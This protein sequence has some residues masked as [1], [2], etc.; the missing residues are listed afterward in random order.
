[1]KK[2]K[3]FF[4]PEQYHGWGETRRYFEGWY[5]K[6]VDHSEKKAFAF[7]PGIAMDETGNRQA[8]I[9]V[10]DGKKNTAIY[11]KFDPSDFIP[12]PGKFEIRI[13][14]NFFSERKIRLNLPEVSGELYFSDN[15][16]WPKHWYSP[17]V[18]GPYSFAPFMECYHGLVSMDHSIK[19]QLEIEGRIINFDNGR[20]YIEKD[21]GRSFP[22][23]YIWMQT[24]HFSDPEI[25]LFASAAK[26]PWRRGS[27][28]GFISGIWIYDRLIQFTT[29][30]K[31]ILR[32]CYVDAGKVEMVME[33]KMHR[34]ELEVKRN[35]STALASPIQGFMA[36]RIE[37]SMTSEVKV[38]LTDVKSGNV[39]FQDKGRNAG[40]DVAGKVEELIV[41]PLE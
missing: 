20:G 36:G 40:L 28:L 41:W 17:G 7:I 23:A 22:S 5:F 31:T 9:Q 10:L 21:W 3:A 14:D 29:Y 27:F 26:I 35:H 39:I 6:V 19:G 1:M 18:M 15:V 12:A 32:K 37:E 4:N 24:N 30:N 2:L 33:N 13:L 16:V 11:R 38:C 8:F 25:S 34:I